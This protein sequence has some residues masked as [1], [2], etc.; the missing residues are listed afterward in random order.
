MV[1]EWTKNIANKGNTQAQVSQGHRA[2]GQGMSM[3]WIVSRGEQRTCL[4]S[5]ARTNHG[6]PDRAS[7][8]LTPTQDSP[9]KLWKQGC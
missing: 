7:E 3:G 6:I 4:E 9:G 2:L 1:D 8:V 5:Y